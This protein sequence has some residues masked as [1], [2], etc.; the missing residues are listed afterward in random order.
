MPHVVETENA[1]LVAIDALSI[2][3]DEDPVGTIGIPMRDQISRWTMMSLLS[4]QW[5]GQV[6]RLAFQGSVLTMQRNAIIQRMRGDWV[7]FIDDD[8]VWESDAVLKLMAGLKELQDQ[9]FEVDIIGGLCFRR[10]SPH[11]PTLYMR[12]ENGTGPYNFMETWDTDIVEVDGTGMAFALITRQCLERLTGAPMPSFEE[13]TAHERH[14]DFF[15]WQGAIGED[16][17]F[18]MDVKSMGGRIFVDTRV[19]TRH[20]AE[21]LAGEETWWEQAALR[22]PEEEAERKAINDRQGLVTLTR[23][24]ARRRL[25][26]TS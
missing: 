15:R 14:H 5:P 1:P 10:G 7:L 20:V 25:G 19:K 3:S 26:W 6:D 16:L 11:Q 2:R 17:R 9:G 22:S 13:R 21:F 12:S 18:C 24:E 23:E 8:M 4:T